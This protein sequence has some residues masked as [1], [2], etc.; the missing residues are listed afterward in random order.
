M[1]E[2]NDQESELKGGASA[3]AVETPASEGAELELRP[4]LVTESAD[5]ARPL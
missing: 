2:P 5:E 3:E 4:D 1:E